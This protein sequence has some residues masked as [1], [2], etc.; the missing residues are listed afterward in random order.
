LRFDFRVK[1]L[2]AFGKIIFDVMVTFENCIC[3]ATRRVEYY[4][5]IPVK[6]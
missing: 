4:I 6:W 1:I 5:I 2:Q 3:Y